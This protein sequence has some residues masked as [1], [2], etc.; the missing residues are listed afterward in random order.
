MSGSFAPCISVTLFPKGKTMKMFLY[1]HP[2]VPISS[3]SMVITGYTHRPTGSDGEPRLDFVLIEI[4]S[5]EVALSH[6]DEKT[7]SYKFT[8]DPQ[9]KPRV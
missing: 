9:G 5:T 3:G 4:E 8:M 7:N 1:V 6:H 2:S